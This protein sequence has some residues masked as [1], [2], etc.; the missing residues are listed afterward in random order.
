VG[1]AVKY[2]QELQIF[3][4]LAVFCP[5][6]I[7]ESLIYKSSALMTLSLGGI[8]D[9]QINEKFAHCRWF[10][11]LATPLAL[12]VLVVADNRNSCHHL[13]TWLK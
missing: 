3:L 9:S 13:P 10:K 5:Q 8:M 11:G 12:L 6:F 1:V 7:Y 4:Q 2:Q